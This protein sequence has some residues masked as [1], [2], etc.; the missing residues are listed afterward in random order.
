MVDISHVAWDPELVPQLRRAGSR[1]VLVQL[2]DSFLVQLHDWSVRPSSRFDRGLMGEGCID[3]GAVLD[4]LDGDAGWF[5]VEALND[6][7]RR[8]S[9]LDRFERA[10]QNFERT[11]AP[12][13]VPAL[14]KSQSH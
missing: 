8:T 12:R 6:E 11:V 9:L 7:L 3:Y 4:G 14:S 2:N 10:A 1:V 13:L 5:E